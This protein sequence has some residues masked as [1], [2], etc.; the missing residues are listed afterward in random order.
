M[1]KAKREYRNKRNER[2]KRKKTGKQPENFHLFPDVRT[3]F[4]TLVRKPGQAQKA[5]K[6]Q[7]E[8]WRLTASGL[9][10]SARHFSAASVCVPCF[11]KCVLTSAFVY[12]LRFFFQTERSPE[13]AFYSIPVFT[14][15]A[16]FQA[17]T[18]R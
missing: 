4:Q 6:W 16:Q 13:L 15:A 1:K 10:F 14:S 3:H 7:A 5:E 18:T 2:N 9:H 17:R 12:I 8:K 11:Y